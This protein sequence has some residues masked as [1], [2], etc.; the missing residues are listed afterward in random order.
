[1]T[2]RR[3][4]FGVRE[5]K[6]QQNLQ[7]RKLKCMVNW[8]E[9]KNNFRLFCS[10]LF[11]FIYRGGDLRIGDTPSTKSFLC[12]RGGTEFLWR[13]TALQTIRCLTIRLLWT[14][15]I[16]YF[17]CVINYIY[18]QSLES[19]AFTRKCVYLLPEMKTSGIH[20]LS[21]YTNTWLSIMMKNL[22]KYLLQ[23]RA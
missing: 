8:A 13:H 6:D 14:M 5:N 16:R 19:R 20:R 9:T 10:L 4:G 15:P 11:P 22:E 21:L 17:L 12:L 3:R 23:T 7:N 18:I 1:M 2:L